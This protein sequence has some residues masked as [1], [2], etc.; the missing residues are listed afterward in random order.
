MD[1]VKFVKKV[2]QRCEFKIAGSVVQNIENGFVMDDCQ[3]EKVLQEMTQGTRKYLC[4]VS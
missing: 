2:Y 3:M 1:V 4:H